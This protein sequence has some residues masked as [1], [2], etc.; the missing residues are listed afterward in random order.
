MSKVKLRACEDT[1]D[2]ARQ[3][4]QT[5]YLYMDPRQR[6]YYIVQEEIASQR[7][8]LQMIVTP[9]GHITVTDNEINQFLRGVK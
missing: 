9:Q 1:F 5:L 8:M 7:S 4:N 3:R 2:M 6:F